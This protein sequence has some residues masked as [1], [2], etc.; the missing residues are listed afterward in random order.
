MNEEKPVRLDDKVQELSL[1]IIILIKKIK[2]IFYSLK[3]GTSEGENV[4]NYALRQN[5][6]V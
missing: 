2:I 1:L 5:S 4:F 6:A 3:K